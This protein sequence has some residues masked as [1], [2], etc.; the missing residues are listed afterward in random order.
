VEFLWGGLDHPLVVW[1]ANLSSPGEGKRTPR[2]MKK[3]VRGELTA[4]L[5][6]YRRERF[7]YLAKERGMALNPNLRQEEKRGEGGSGR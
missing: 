4:E 7:S 5:R 1:K 2:A 6:P 3:R